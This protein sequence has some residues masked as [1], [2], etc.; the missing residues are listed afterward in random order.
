MVK[1]LG[2]VRAFTNARTLPRLAGFF[3][4]SRACTRVT[5]SFASSALSNV[6][7]PRFAGS[8]PAVRCWSLRA[9]VR[10]G[11]PSRFRNDVF[12][13]LGSHQSF[14]SSKDFA[15]R[16]RN[17]L[18]TP[19]DQLRR[20]AFGFLGAVASNM[21]CNSSLAAAAAAVSLLLRARTSA[22]VLAFFFFV[23]PPALA[24]RGRPT[25]RF[26]GAKKDLKEA[27]SPPSYTR[28]CLRLALAGRPIS[29]IMTLCCFHGFVF[30]IFAHG[31]K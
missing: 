3:A 20:V 2:L 7:R 14:W 29:I 26:A 25:L 19:L 23:F 5:T 30:R 16:S 18:A 8:V 6:C 10:W 4:S 9:T 12:V 17:C 15:P 1:P 24:L 21:V 11:M 31:K 13:S 27:A 22:F 28:P